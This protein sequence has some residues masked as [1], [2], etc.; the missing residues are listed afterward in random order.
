MM[1]KLYQAREEGD[2][3][4]WIKGH[5]DSS[6]LNRKQ[7]PHAPNVYVNGCLVYALKMENGRLW[8]CKTG[9]QEQGML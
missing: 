4:K 2:W 7:D 6:M 8:N 3:Q 1:P 9:W 5:V